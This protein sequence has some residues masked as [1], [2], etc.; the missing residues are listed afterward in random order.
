MKLPAELVARLGPHYNGR[1]VAVTGG[2]GFIGGHLVDA[3]VSL[4][5]SIRVLD[6]LSNASLDHLSE[7]IELEPQRVR[8][9]HGSILDQ[10]AADEACEG[11][12]VVFH[13]AAVGSVPLSIEQ[14]ERSWAVNADGTVRM[15]E[16]ARRHGV[17]RF[18]N[19]SSS[20]VYGDGQ[21]EAAQTAPKSE[22]QMPSPRSPYAASKLAAEAAVRAWCRSLGMSGLSLR[23]FNV[24]GP[25]QRADSAYAA[26]IAAFARRLMSGETPVIYGDGQ[27]SRD[28]TPVASVV[29]ANLLAGVCQRPCDGQAV[30][31]GTGRRTDLLALF[32][33]MAGRLGMQHVRPRFEPE[34]AGDVRH[35]L[36]D[37]AAAKALLDYAPIGTVDQ[38]ID[39]TLD[40]YRRLY[41]A[42]GS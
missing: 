4:G 35:S 34:R 28:F 10:A 11:A 18:V 27:Q 33:L 29:A 26:V 41:V 30:N 16:A 37:I 22:S 39:E 8:F 13:L 23:Y 12:Q 6:D 24:F 15:L 38:A 31:I 5:A 14:P 20:S 25:R 36:A 19:S 42:S 21:S 7:L 32:A 9:I 3:L 1:A 40:W 2:A 17:R